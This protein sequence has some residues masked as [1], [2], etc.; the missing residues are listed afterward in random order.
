LEGGN[1]CDFRRVGVVLQLAISPI[2]LFLF[3]FAA[4]EVVLEADAKE[5]TVAP[6]EEEAANVGEPTAEFSGALVCIV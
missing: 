2:S 1:L 6:V 4:E 3:I 5:A